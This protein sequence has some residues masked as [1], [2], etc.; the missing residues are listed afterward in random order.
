MD[1]YETMLLQDQNRA[2]LRG[3]VSNRGGTSAADMDSAFVAGGPKGKCYYFQEGQCNR[4]NCPFLH[5]KMNSDEL[6][7]MKESG[8]GKG[9]GKGKGK[10]GD[11]KR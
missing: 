1:R 2:K 9:K 8:S 5:E 4:K 3:A 6:A 7:K 10:K 11:G